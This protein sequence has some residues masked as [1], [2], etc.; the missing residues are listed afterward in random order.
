MFRRWEGEGEHACTAVMRP[1]YASLTPAC[2]RSSASKP[3]PAAASP[4]EAQN[5]KGLLLGAA[6]FQVTTRRSAMAATAAAAGA[7]SFVGAEG[8]GPLTGGG[9]VVTSDGKGWVP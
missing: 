2:A 3:A 7:A 6:M 5:S 1:T 8:I 4:H 9:E